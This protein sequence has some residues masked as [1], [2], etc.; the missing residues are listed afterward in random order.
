MRISDSSSDRELLE[1]SRDGDSSAFSELWRRHHRPALVAAQNFTTRF[2]AEDVVAEAYLKIFELVARGKGPTGAFRPY[3]YRV[4]RSVAVDWSRSP[5]SSSAPLHEHLTATEAG[6]WEDEDFDR[7]AAAQAFLSLN[8]R[9]QEVLWYTEVEGLRPREVAKLVGTNARNV[10]ALASRAREELRSAW[11]EQHVDRELADGACRSTL[12]HLQRYQRGKLTAARHRDVEA[13]LAHC[14]T[15]TRAAA[16]YAILNRH[17]ALALATIFLGGVGA[18][19]LLQAFGGTAAETS[20]ALGATHSAGAAPPVPKP[21]AL[22]VGAGAGAAQ[23]IAFIAVAGAAAAAVIG[24]TI[25]AVSHSPSQSPSPEASVEASEEISVIDEESRRAD[26]AQEDRDTTAEQDGTPDD[27]STEIDEIVVGGRETASASPAPP[28]QSPRTTPPEKEIEIPGDREPDGGNEPSDSGSEG[29][30]GEE[31]DPNLDP[32][33]TIGFE[34]H[35]DSPV[36]GFILTGTASEY[37][38]LRARITQ[39]PATEPVLL[40]TYPT[41]TDAYGNTFENVFSGTDP[42]PNPWWWTP[43]L[44]PLDQ[45]PGL[46]PANIEDV[47]IEMQLLHPDGRY[48]P[49]IPVELAQS[50]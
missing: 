38:A 35:L 47:V 46:S 44:T 36:Q 32:S 4:V 37:G 16:E 27:R 7:N 39:P 22:K 17:L 45:W 24:G 50:C 21:S 31:P 11:V 6:P 3:L 28:T 12:T 10:S 14:D 18:A 23:Q 9:W 25:L 2:P 8:S 40:V 15:C 48:S 20:I 29:E 26:P 42:M 1:A 5:E 30:A 49:W 43:S 13:H 19:S 34:C 41:V 33:L